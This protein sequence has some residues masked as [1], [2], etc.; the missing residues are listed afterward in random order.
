MVNA[1]H[2]GHPLS[3]SI[4]VPFIPKSKSYFL[5]PVHAHFRGREK[6]ALDDQ[7]AQADGSIW[8]EVVSISKASIDRVG[9]E[10]ILY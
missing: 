2:G 10:E 9:Y 5:F 6:Q 8:M 4:L 3:L 1:E 7:P